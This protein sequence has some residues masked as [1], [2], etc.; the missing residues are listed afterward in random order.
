MVNTWD[1]GLRAR[2]IVISGSG[3]PIILCAVDWLG[4]ANEGQDAFKAALAE[5]VNTD[6]ERIA[7]HTLHQHDAPICD[8][9]SERILK[10]NNILP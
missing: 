3:K 10:S 2:G 8:F 9:S 7:V 1:L 5:A 4:I 6:P